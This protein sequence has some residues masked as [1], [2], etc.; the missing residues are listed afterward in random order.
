MLGLRW[1]GRL[2]K[3]TEQQA[4]VSALWSKHNAM[5]W[6]HQRINCGTP[7]LYCISESEK[8][9]FGFGPFVELWLTWGKWRIIFFVGLWGVLDIL[10]IWRMAVAVEQKRRPQNKRLTYL[11]ACY[12]SRCRLAATPP[13]PSEMKNTSSVAKRSWNEGRRRRQR[14]REQLSSVFSPVRRRD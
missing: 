13:W 1:V 12:L 6:P 4:R 8:T 11:L 10:A 3:T 5:M 14:R 2:V 7:T 9:R